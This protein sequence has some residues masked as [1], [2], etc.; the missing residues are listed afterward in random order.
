MN[1][2]NHV[3][4][5]HLLI[6]VLRLFFGHALEC[7]LSEYKVDMDCCPKCPAGNRVISDCSESSSTSCLPCVR[8]T[9]L[10]NPSGLKK[11]FTCKTCDPGSGLRTKRACTAK[12]DSVCEPMDGFHC[13]DFTEGSCAAAEKHSSSCQPGYYISHQG[14]TFKG[15]ECSTCG[16]GTYSDGSFMSCRPHT[17]CEDMDL[18]LVKPGNTSADSECIKPTTNLIITTVVVISMIVLLLG[19]PLIYYVLRVRGWKCDNAVTQII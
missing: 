4:T 5:A 13:I 8:G 18:L 14:N 17:K 10:P 2:T 7:H 6:I 15:T 11:C 3:F 16:N 19:A 12:S 1:R 9:F